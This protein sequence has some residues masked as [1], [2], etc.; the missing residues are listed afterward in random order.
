[1]IPTSAQLRH[2]CGL[3]KWSPLMLVWNVKISHDSARKIC[4]GY[5]TATVPEEHR[6]AIQGALVAAGI[7]FG[8][9]GAGVRLRKVDPA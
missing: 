5:D 6:Q 8:G 9:D 2:A 4:G 1:M 3:V 7:E